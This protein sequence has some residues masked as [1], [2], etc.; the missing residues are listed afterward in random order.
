MNQSL[1]ANLKE[2]NFSN[3]VRQVERLQQR[4]NPPAGNPKGA[5]AG[6]FR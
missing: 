2:Q 6:G 4:Y 5:P 1:D 3:S